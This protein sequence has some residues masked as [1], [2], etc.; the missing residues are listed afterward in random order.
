[1]LKI[2]PHKQSPSCCGP[3]SLKMVADYYDI[4]KS[5]RQ[6]ARLSGCTLAS[7]T[8][9]EGLLGC[10]KK[11]GLKGFIKDFADIKDIRYYVIKKK[12]PIIV[13]WFSQTGVSD[14]HYSVVVHIDNEKI[15]FVDPEFGEIRSHNINDFKRIWFDFDVP[16]LR[17]KKD[18]II[19]RMIVLY[20]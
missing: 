19:R 12:F 4:K 13:N 20:K 5:E 2:N 11:I 16:F 1:M 17:S 9:G 18:L 7:G 8:T 10:G 3:S 6:L 14:G 15:Y